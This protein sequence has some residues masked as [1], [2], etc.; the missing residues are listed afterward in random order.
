MNPSLRRVLDLIRTNSQSE[1][2]K[3]TRFEHL[4]KRYLETDPV[5][6][7]RFSHVWRWVDWPYRGGLADQG[8]DLV[9][10]E[11]STG[12]Y[13]AIQ[14]KCYE[15][16][17]TLNLADVGTFFTTL[18]ML[19]KTEQGTLPFARGIIIATTDRWNDKLLNT[20]AKQARPCQRIAL[21]NLEEAGIDWDSA[22]AG[23][24][25]AVTHYAP[26]PQ[27][28]DAIDDVLRGFEQGD[29]GRLIM[30]CGTGKTFT[31]LRLAE[32]LTDG[33]G[34]LL[35]LVPSISL[36][37]QALRSWMEQANEPMHA[38]A[39]CSDAKASQL[40][41]DDE[42]DL[43]A[44]NLPVPACTDPTSVAKQYAYWQQRGGLVVVF[45]TYQ[46]IQVVSEAQ[47]LGGLPEF[48][49]IICDEAHRTT[50]VALSK[51]GGGYDESQFVLVHSNDNVRGKKRLYMTA[52]PRIYGETGKKR[53]E[54]AD[55]WLA[56]MDDETI[57]GPEFHRLPFSKAV[58]E[59]LLA[60]YKVLV[61]CVDED[62]VREKFSTM[63]RENGGEY[64]LE[65]MV[66]LLGCYNGLRKRVL[67]SNVASGEEWDFLDKNPMKRAVAFAGRIA[68]SKKVKKAFEQMLDALRESG[69]FLECGIEHVDG[70][71]NAQRRNEALA[72]LKND[73]G[74]EECRVL[75]NAR[76]LS[77]GV[78]VPALDAVM[79]LAPMR[80]QIDIVQAVG[81]VMRT[82][83]GKKYGYILLPIGVPRDKKP[84]EV[85][86][87]RESK[88][89][90]VWDVLQALRAHDDRFNAQI[91]QIELNRKPADTVRV[92]GVA[93]GN[94]GEGDGAG[95]SAAG[96]GAAEQTT[97]E[98]FRDLPFWQDAIFARIVKKCGSRR[99]W[100]DW[101]K[102]IAHIAERQIA[103]ITELLQAGH[104]E[105]EFGQ[106]LQGLHNSINP[107][108][109]RTQAI[110]MLAQQVIT[111]PVFDALF[112]NYRFAELNPVSQ[113]MNA[114]LQLVQ[115]SMAPDDARQLKNFYD[116]VRERT[117]GIDNAAGR[118]K[119][120]T[121]LYDKFFKNAFPKMAEAL[122]IVYTPVEI[123]DYIVRSVHA[124]LQKEFDVQEGLGA[125]G[126]KILD[127]FTGTGT[128]IVR[129]LQS[130]L[131]KKRDL[132]YK[133]KNDLFASEIVLLA[134]YIACVNIEETY[135]ECAGKSTYTPFDGICLTD[136][137]R[138]DATGKN[139]LAEMFSDNARRVKRVVENDIKVIIGNPPYSVGQRSAND[140]NQNE[141]YPDLDARIAETYAAGTKAT[142]KNSL[143]D[144]Y[145]RAFRWAS[146]RVQGDGVIGFVTNGGIIDKNAMNGFRR[147][148]L[149]EFAAVYCFNLRG[150]VRGKSGLEAKKEGG[151][152][153]NIM[154]GVCITL[155]VK[156]KDHKGLGRLFYRDIGDYLSREQKLN[157]IKSLQDMT[158]TDWE[159]LQMDEHGD[160]LNHR[161][162]GFA[163]FIPLG[164][165]ECKG[166]RGGQTIFKTYSRGLETSRDAWCYNFSRKRLKQNI[167]D[168][169][170]YYN[171]C[172]GN[173]KVV[174]NVQRFSWTRKSKRQAEIGKIF[175][176]NPSSYREAVYRLFNR[177]IVYFNSDYNEY[178]N[179][180]PVI[181]PTEKT[182]NFIICL[183][184]P[185]DR[186]SFSVLI[187]NVICDLHLADTTQCF[188]LYWYEKRDK[189]ENSLELDLGE[190]EGDYIRHQ[191]ITDYAL[192]QFRTVYSDPKIS[193]EDIFYYVYGLLHSPE[194]RE[195]FGADLKKML[196]RIPYAKD[197]RAFEKAGR[198]LADLHL[199]YERAVPC[200]LVQEEGSAASLRVD[201][202]RFLD[203]KTKDT[204]IYNRTLSL[205]H[206]PAKTY[207]YQVNGKSALE[208]V[209]ERYSVT[210][211]KAS[212]IV[213]DPNLW[214]DE[215]NE[216]RYIVDLIKRVVT[217]SLETVDIVRSLPPLQELN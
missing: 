168:S 19:W 100:E 53:A 191:G 113:T 56:S 66:K 32:E 57:Y 203:K 132:E 29:R 144:S 164:D 207:E 185:G 27:Q 189:E 216:P 120:I 128:F 175:L 184:S 115:D 38:I 17:H 187:S 34:C 10:Q 114:M 157:C 198:K 68:V 30:A 48:D 78:D 177:Q 44:D 3:G 82:A 125:H 213:N 18:G 11:A 28:R 121:E 75:T 79:F 117:Q 13:V 205:T 92:V 50:G 143:Y 63:L 196:P 90:T 217:V 76:C 16:T 106:F 173:H 25:R 12:D 149:E 21:S 23:E 88:Y 59:G 51:A 135:H 188:P 112:E 74:A 137:F 201:K 55:A 124:I 190:R 15:E 167:A 159:E 73:E 133:F 108:I 2:D 116:S 1:S 134:Y 130:G 165:K 215:H 94:G 39:V 60:D 97:E 107:S 85:L 80:S 204:I 22:A 192:K 43:T 118:Q 180:W 136:T 156:K 52:T 122:G 6:R 84:E 7:D 109:S 166:D 103:T 202:L 98:L 174:V 195:R 119:V 89:A 58:R 186:K 141:D 47:K 65:D 77:E 142:N 41:K 96:L 99:Y 31:S 67:H 162:P 172:A 199:H 179:L 9:A 54:A 5:Y 145:I 14:C 129:L 42:L 160:W 139:M 193:R 208:W 209:V 110:E 181:F 182:E 91:N 183:S 33:K 37:S 211:D 152:V 61:L 131:I 81:R 46:S 123:V 87:D 153:F 83:A 86:G 151:N 169:I 194:Y 158:S 71:M 148:L 206:I 101:A 24:L 104:G 178:Q 147:C 127:P 150:F 197:F 146:D 72:W 64:E 95:A 105:R 126:V 161:D 26:R 93:G 8:V 62:Y 200:A 214:C 69:D 70:T 212:G 36:L 163:Q 171:L 20:M 176:E 45:S 111:R 35:F 102:D 49:L 155:M 4:M 210:T 154:T 140:N 40:A 138:M 170:A